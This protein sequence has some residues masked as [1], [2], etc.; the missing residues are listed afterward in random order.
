MVDLRTNPV[1]FYIILFSISTRAYIYQNKTH[2]YQWYM[3]AEY[4]K[5]YV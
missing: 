4:R 2:R 3:S 5:T 1:F